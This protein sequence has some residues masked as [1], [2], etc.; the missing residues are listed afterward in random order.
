MNRDKIISFDFDGVMANSCKA[1]TQIY[2]ELYND[3]QDYRNNKLWSFA[4]VCPKSNPQEINSWFDTDI[5]FDRLEPFMDVINIMRE[6]YTSGYKIAIVTCHKAK[7]MYNKSKFIKK[8]I[9]FPVQVIYI[10]LNENDCIDKSVINTYLHVD[11]SL[12]ALD[13]IQSKYKIC[14]GDYHYNNTDKY[15]KVGN[16]KELREE[17][18]KII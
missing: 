6:S 1:I 14:F 10:E 4:D 13:T 12:S 18:F 3:N 16:A 9:D 2:N 11:D 17:I 7:G 15:I 8:Y 5:F